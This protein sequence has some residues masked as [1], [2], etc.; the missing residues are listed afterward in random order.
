VTAGDISLLIGAVAG[1][2]AA[3]AGF[4]SQWQRKAALDADQLEKERNRLR[5]RVEGLLR[6]IH[7]LRTLLAEHGIEAPPV[8]DDHTEG[9]R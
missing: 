3:I 5:R 2:I 7:A 8:P 1:L 4:V 6:H 9:S